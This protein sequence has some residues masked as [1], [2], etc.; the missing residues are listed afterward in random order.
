MQTRATVA[1]MSAANMILASGLPA[2]ATA[3]QYKGWARFALNNP[4]DEG[5]RAMWGVI[6]NTAVVTNGPTA[7]D[8]QVFNAVSAFLPVLVSTF[9]T[10]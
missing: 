6:T 9:P 3:T 10:A 1:C 8:G 2:G 7:T 5:R 4:G